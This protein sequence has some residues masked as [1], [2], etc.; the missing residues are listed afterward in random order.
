[1]HAS[2][3]ANGSLAYL[4]GPVKIVDRP[5][6]LALFDRKGGNQP[7]GLPAGTYS[8]PRASPDGRFVAFEK[9]DVRGTNVWLYELSA[10]RAAQQITFGGNNRAPVWTPDSRSIAFQSNREGDEAI[11][12]QRAD[13]SGVAERLS[14][15]DAGTAHIPQSWSRDGAHLLFSVQKGSEFTLWTMTVKDRKAAPFGGV[16]AREASFSP[17][18]R[19]VAYGVREESTNVVYVEPFPR[20]G[21]KYLVLRP[22][23]HPFWS[24]TG[25][26]VIMNVAPQRSSIVSIATSP[27]FAFGKP[28]D[29][30]RPGQ[31]GDPLTARRNA[32]MMPDGRVIGVRVA[33]LEPDPRQIVVVL[34]WSEELK[35]RVPAN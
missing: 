15:P 12:L 16:A 2:Y 14:K 27:R 28:V 1:V 25:D 35:R 31:Q 34:N 29:F 13:G 11:F 8:A 7:L 22:A 32:D 24:R 17:D 3:S 30:A 6:D 23:G 10:E 18:G 9:A 21:A 5:T 20:T 33:E 4:P 19:W 26:E